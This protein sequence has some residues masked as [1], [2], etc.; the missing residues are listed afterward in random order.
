MSSS[1][2]LY[3]QDRATEGPDCAKILKMKIFVK[4]KNEAV[5]NFLERYTQA[6]M[7]KDLRNGFML[8]PNFRCKSSI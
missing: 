2:G 7:S 8:W 5:Y 4:C 3:W 6:N 1:R